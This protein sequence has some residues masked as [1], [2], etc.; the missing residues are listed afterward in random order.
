MSAEA[1]AGKHKNPR[2]SIVVDPEVLDVFERVAELQGLTLSSFMRSWMKLSMPMLK[3]ALDAV[4]SA[5]SGNAVEALLT[6]SSQTSRQFNDQQLDLLDLVEEVKGAQN[7]PTESRI[8][9]PEAKPKK[10]GRASKA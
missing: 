9:T 1:R 2:I 7:A 3:Q 4:D 5:K 6:Y 8:M 10:R